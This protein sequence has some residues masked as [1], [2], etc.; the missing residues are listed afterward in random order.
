MNE[1]LHIGLQCRLLDDLQGERQVLKKGEAQPMLVQLED[2][3]GGRKHITR[4]SGESPDMS[5]PQR[6]TNDIALNVTIILATTDLHSRLLSSSCVHPIR[7]GVCFAAPTVLFFVLT[8]METYAIEPDE[9]ATALQRQFQSS[10]SVAKLPGK[11]ADIGKE[12]ALQVV[13][14]T[15]QTNM[16]RSVSAFI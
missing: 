6:L 10:A 16:P 7:K 8:G 2:R 9:L 11:A 13:R 14:S 1:A 12:I 4:I 5:Y 15:T 3:A